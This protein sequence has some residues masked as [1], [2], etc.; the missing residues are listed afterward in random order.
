[1]VP[2]LYGKQLGSVMSDYQ[3]VSGRTDIGMDHEEIR[4]KAGWYNAEQL[5]TN[6]P[7]YVPQHLEEVVEKPKKSSRTRNPPP[8]SQ[9]GT[10]DEQTRQNSR[11]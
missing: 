7:G 2:A 11:R 8:G 9:A 1:M 3:T 10:M 4:R 5:Q 6:N